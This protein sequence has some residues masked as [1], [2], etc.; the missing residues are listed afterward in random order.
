MRDAE[1]LYGQINSF[2]GKGTR[3][4]WAEN[5]KR[6]GTKAEQEGDLKSALA[7]FKIAAKIEGAMETEITKIQDPNAWLPAPTIEFSSD[8]EVFINSQKIPPTDFEEVK[9]ESE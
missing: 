5:F 6:L 1:D 2:T 4:L 9:P 3:T 7:S 8:P